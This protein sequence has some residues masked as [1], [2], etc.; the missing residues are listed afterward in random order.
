M[1]TKVEPAYINQ[2]GYLH[3]VTLD[4]NLLEGIFQ[5]SGAIRFGD[6]ALSVGSGT[7]GVAIAA[8]RYFILGQENATQGGYFAWSDAV[9]NVN[10]A[11]AVGNP[12]IDTILLRIYDD[13]YGVITGSPRAQIDVVQGV[14][15]ASPT[16][17]VDADFLSGGSQYVPGAWARLG[18]VRVNVTDTGALPAGQIT[19]ANRYVRVPGG[20]V[21]CLSTARPS[22]PVI[23]DEIY[24]TDTKFTREWDGSAWVQIKP[25]ILYSNVGSSTALHSITGIPTSLRKLR[26]VWNARSTQATVAQ[27]MFMRI[28]NVNTASYTWT[29]GQINNITRTAPVNT[30]AADTGMRVG[31]VGGASAAANNLGHGVIDI[32]GWSNSWI[33][34]THQN[35]F[36]ETPTNSWLQE[37]SG[38]Y[39]FAGPYNRLDFYMDLGN[40][41]AGSFFHLEGW[42]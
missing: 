20:K 2:T 6:Y 22:D 29:I 40:V 4:R 23:G 18:D 14:A 24:E 3:P 9:D 26:V 31:V 16:A 11:A 41:A 12:R 34:Q 13:Q 17:R 35:H 5:R 32:S 37:G 39:P 19:T 33:H 8:G 30:A 27:N 21:L 15:A 7:R 1:V 10:L 25:W 38:Q 42:E 28:N 36:W